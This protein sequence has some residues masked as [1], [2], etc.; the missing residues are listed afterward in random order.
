MDTQWTLTVP[1]QL[2]HD[3]AVSVRS[4]SGEFTR[5]TR[6]STHQFRLG[7]PWN[8][9]SRD[10]CF[11][12]DS[13]LRNAAVGSSAGLLRR[14]ARG[15][16]RRRD[17]AGTGSVGTNRAVALAAYDQLSRLGRCWVERSRLRGQATTPTRKRCGVPPGRKIFGSIRAQRARDPK[18]RY[19]LGSI[20]RR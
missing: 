1:G 10:A 19:G 14:G 7:N 9:V 13:K 5:S 2:Q 15:R 17:V 20:R 11:R 6:R 8:P 12:G 3:G 4:M 16:E 18:C